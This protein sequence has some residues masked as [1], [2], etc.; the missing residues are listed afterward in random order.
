MTELLQTAVLEFYTEYCKSRQVIQ[1]Q[2]CDCALSL[3]PMYFSLLRVTSQKYVP[4][5]I[6]PVHA[7]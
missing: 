4:A 2:E 5:E 3:C 1:T 6:F 7:W